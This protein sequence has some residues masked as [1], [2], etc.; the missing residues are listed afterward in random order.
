MDWQPIETAPKDGREIILTD[1]AFVHVGRFD[2]AD[3]RSY[4]WRF[5]DRTSLGGGALNGWR[6]DGTGPRHW[7]LLPLPPINSTP[8][9]ETD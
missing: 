6:D 8:T 2:P 9:K 1:G 5:L 4:P 3:D 7:M